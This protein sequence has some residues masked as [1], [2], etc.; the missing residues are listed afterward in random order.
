MYQIVRRISKALGFAA[1]LYFFI[2]LF[3]MLPDL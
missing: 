2:S 3:H 1:L